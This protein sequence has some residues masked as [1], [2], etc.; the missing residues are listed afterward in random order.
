VGVFP[1]HVIAFS[2]SSVETPDFFCYP[3]FFPERREEK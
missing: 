1:G 3:G 2:L